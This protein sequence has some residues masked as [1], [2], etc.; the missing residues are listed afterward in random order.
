MSGGISATTVLLATTA[1]VGAYA[2]IQSGKAAKQ[3]A[4]D[5][6]EIARRNAAQG[7][8][9]AVAQA[10][11]IR[12]AAAQQKASATAQLAAS[13]VSVNDGTAV[14]INDQIT[15]NAEQDAFTTILNGSRSAASSL[16]QATM[17]ENQGK[18]ALQGGYLNAGASLLSSGSSIASG[19]KASVPSGGNA[20]GGFKG[21]SS[22]MWGNT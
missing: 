16:N 17:F 11:K 8:D 2:S 6:A 10:E 1:A 5:N 4:D 19:W 3:A 14:N 22:L 15:K 9:A 21:S 13:G 20:A 7:Q 18:S 12:R